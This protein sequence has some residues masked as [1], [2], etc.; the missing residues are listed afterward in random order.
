MPK[1][2]I[3][4]QGLIF[5][6][7]TSGP[8]GK[9]GPRRHEALIWLDG[10]IHHISRDNSLPDR[11]W[12]RMHP[13][14]VPGLTEAD[15]PAPLAASGKPGRY[16]VD[17]NYYVSCYEALIVRNGQLFRYTHDNIEWI[18]SFP[19]PLTKEVTGVPTIFH[20]LDDFLGQI[21]TTL[22]AMV[23]TQ[24][25]LMHF[26][27]APSWDFWIPRGI[28][29]MRAT[30][31]R[32]TGQLGWPTGFPL[33]QG[34]Y[35]VFVPIDGNLRRFRFDVNWLFYGWDEYGESNI[36]ARHGAATGV[37]GL[38]AIDTNLPVPWL[39]H[40]D[41]H[42]LVPNIDSEKK[43]GDLIHYWGQG[44]SPNPVWQSV[45]I[46]GKYTG[47]ASVISQGQP[48]YKPVA[49]DGN[50]NEYLYALAPYDRDIYA[51][52]RNGETGRWSEPKKVI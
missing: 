2:L 3:A 44:L 12:F 45:V 15:F 10:W 6:T 5:G 39:V 51:I 46:P 33:T 13:P 22:Q 41:F 26:S 17:G 32:V 9:H 43:E 38:P 27:Y 19:H 20:A 4:P 28:V 16:G 23:P 14:E 35:V 48:N 42:L 24:Q 18:Q 21:P 34:G 8:F 40:D 50:S 52:E 30:R 36:E 47:N 1:A 37:Q 7:V 11:P 29:T 49:S 25:G 31:Q